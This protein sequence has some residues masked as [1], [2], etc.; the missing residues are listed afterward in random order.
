LNAI[1][2]KNDFALIAVADRKNKERSNVNGVSLMTVYIKPKRA[3]YLV[4]LDE[5]YRN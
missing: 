2:E 5:R 4:L 1:P 3:I